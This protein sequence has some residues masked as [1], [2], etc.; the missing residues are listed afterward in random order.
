M[1]VELG[2]TEL[3]QTSLCRPE[4]GGEENNR[5]HPEQKALRRSLAPCQEANA[6]I[7]ASAALRE[8][9]LCAVAVP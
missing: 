9:P 2:G 7:S 8:L 1:G 4:D 3:P 6:P 5:G